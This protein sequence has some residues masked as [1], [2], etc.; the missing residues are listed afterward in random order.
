VNAV[1]L[2]PKRERPLLPCN[3]R[4]YFFSLLQNLHPVSLVA[5]YLLFKV[6]PEEMA[7]KVKVMKDDEA[8]ATAMKEASAKQTKVVVDFNATW[9]GPCKAIGIY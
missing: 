3:V 9:C 6:N 1:F 7:S 5:R 4:F 2:W 8:F